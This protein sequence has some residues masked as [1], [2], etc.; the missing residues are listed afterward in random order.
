M[1]FCWRVSSQVVLST[2][3]SRSVEGWS[4]RWRLCAKQVEIYRYI[5]SLNRLFSAL[6]SQLPSVTLGGEWGSCPLSPQVPIPFHT[7]LGQSSNVFH[8]CFILLKFCLFQH[9]LPLRWYCPS[10][11][12]A[13]DKLRACGKC[14]CGC[15]S[16]CISNS[17]T[18]VT[19]CWTHWTLLALKQCCSEPW[20]VLAGLAETWSET[21]D[22][23]G[24]ENRWMNVDWKMGWGK[25]SNR[26]WTFSL[27]AMASVHVGV[28]FA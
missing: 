1:L 2:S 17:W 9:S 10:G 26:V 4:V 8:P 13:K 22:A 23:G 15:S 16:Q 18:H 25:H 11:I 7:S 24:E 28:A 5:I 20:G 19:T 14:L 27:L 3:E 6:M 21:V 12:W